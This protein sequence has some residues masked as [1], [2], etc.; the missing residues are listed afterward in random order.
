MNKYSVIVFDLG[1]VLIPFD[2]EPVIQKFNQL[3]PNLG[4]KFKVLY[5]ANYHIHQ[6]FERGELTQDKFLEIMLDWLEGI[7]SADEFCFL[8]SN[9][10][11]INQ[12]VVELLPMLKEE[13]K[14]ILLSNT[15]EMHKRYGYGKFKFLNY[16]D[17]LIL[18]HEVGAIKPEEKIYRTVE[19]FTQKQSS[20]H[21]FID[22][23]PEYVEGAK[24]CGW[25]GTQFVGYEKLV[26]IL[27]AES[28]L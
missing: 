25:N 13:Y 17:K 21:F 19:A 18:S 24:K 26:E 12:N 1:K 14:L 28:I 20:E 3:K 5:A 7:I 22:D 15:N 2:Y 9:I 4:N 11:T 10:F 23:I 8:F 27:K 16:F 6:Q